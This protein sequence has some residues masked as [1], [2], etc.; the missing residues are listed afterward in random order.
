MN[1]LLAELDQLLA[2]R[3]KLEQRIAAIKFQLLLLSC[4]A[5]LSEGSHG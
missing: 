5:E 1:T 2:A 3:G 4:G